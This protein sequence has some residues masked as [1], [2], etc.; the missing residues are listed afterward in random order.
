M[1]LVEFAPG[2]RLHRDAPVSSALPILNPVPPATWVVFADGRGLGVPTDQIV[3][4]DAAA[5]AARVGFAG[6]RFDGV[7]DGALVFRRVAEMR[8]EHTL[9]PERGRVLEVR[10]ADVARVLVAGREVWPGTP[11]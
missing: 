9:A 6:M 4:G 10:P 1:T 7:E 3:H 2:S 8:P 11:A 5:G